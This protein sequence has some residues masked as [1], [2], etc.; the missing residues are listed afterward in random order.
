M[1]NTIINIDSI[2]IFILVILKNIIIIPINVH[3]KDIK[4]FGLFIVLYEM[5]DI[6]SKR[7]LSVPSL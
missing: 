5:E 7:T 6:S 3:A 1:P 2:R 4:T